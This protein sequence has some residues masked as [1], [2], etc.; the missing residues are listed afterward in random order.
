M[1]LLLR[2]GLFGLFDALVGEGGIVF[3]E[4]V[5]F[6]GLFNRFPGSLLFAFLAAYWA[7]IA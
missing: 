5:V 4:M 7:L 6:V 3:D 1:D 2:I